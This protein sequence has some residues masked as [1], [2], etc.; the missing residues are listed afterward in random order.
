[1]VENNQRSDGLIAILVTDDTSLNF[2]YDIATRTSHSGTTD[3]ADCMVRMTSETFSRLL[4]G[5]STFEREA[6][7]GSLTISGD[8]H[9]L[10][11]FGKSL[12]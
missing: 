7:E 2:S 11:H 8:S 1:M 3:N 4:D 5:T 9:L 12:R 10:R 6:Y